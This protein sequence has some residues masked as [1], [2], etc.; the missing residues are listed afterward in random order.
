MFFILSS[1]HGCI[2]FLKILLF[3]H[4]FPSSGG[5]KLPNKKKTGA[6]LSFAGRPDRMTGVGGVGVG[7]DCFVKYKVRS[8]K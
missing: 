5:Q 6:G 7:G 4:L 1:L 8:E 2:F 3:S